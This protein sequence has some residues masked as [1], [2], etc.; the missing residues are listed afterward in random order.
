[1]AQKRLR[2]TPPRVV[3]LVIIFAIIVAGITVIGIFVGYYRAPPHSTTRR[4]RT[5]H[6]PPKPQNGKISHRQAPAA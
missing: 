5:P 4:I 6:Q 3:R 2:L 1:M